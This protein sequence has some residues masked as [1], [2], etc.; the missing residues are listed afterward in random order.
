MSFEVLIIRSAIGKFCGYKPGFIALGMLLEE[1]REE[2]QLENC[3]DDEQF[4]EDDGPKRLAETHGAEPV[5][6]QVES[7]IKE[8]V[9]GHRHTFTAQIYIIYLKVPNNFHFLLYFHNIC[10]ILHRKIETF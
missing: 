8:T 9:R 2:E 6:I 10:I 4:N 5:V 3:E 1:V 7:P